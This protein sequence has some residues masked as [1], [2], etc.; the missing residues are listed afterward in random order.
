MNRA[1]ELN[2]I[3][4]I[5]R[6]TDL[7]SI[8]HEAERRFHLAVVAAE[9]DEAE[10]LARLLG[11][12][13]GSVHP[14]LSVHAAPLDSEAIRSPV[15]LALFLS[16]QVELSPSLR[17]GLEA[18]AARQVPVVVVVVRPG[19]A[20]V[21]ADLPRPGEATRVVVDSLDSAIV[22]RDVASA[23]LRAAPP[24]LRLALGRR[25]PPMR[26]LLFERLIAE[27]SRANAGYSFSTGIA[28]VIPVLNIPL[29]LGDFVILTK[30]QILMSY[31]IALV[32]GKEGS[33]RKLVGE[34]LGVLGGGILFRQVARQLIGLVPVL[35]I[36]P[37]VAV[38]Y[39]GTWAIGRAVVLWATEGQRVTP[40]T[41]R[42]FYTE[43]LARG[44]QYARHLV[45]R[46]RRTRPAELPPPAPPE[47]SSNPRP[48]FWQRLR[49]RLPF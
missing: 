17:T 22:E 18:F 34:I 24:D 35:G 33:P 26:S 46:A 5:L 2:S 19:G 3:W 23:L 16:D 14:W 36:A 42:Q 12:D 37:K 45:T 8:R 43:A 27:T 28:E 25:L 15:D 30:N 41:V 7:E 29:N 48:G 1:F 11:G 4:Q 32:A 6:Q 39:A 20:G 38:A 49:R 10:R 40:E 31:K 13:D 44:K 47:G 9:R 21:S